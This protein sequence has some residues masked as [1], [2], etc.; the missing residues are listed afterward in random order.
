M[1]PNNAPFQVKDPSIQSHIHIN[2]YP[3]SPAL[4]EKPKQLTNARNLPE[5]H[6]HELTYHF[7]TLNRTSDQFIIYSGNEKEKDKLE[8]IAVTDFHFRNWSVY[9]PEKRINEPI[10]PLSFPIGPLIFYYGITLNNGILLHAAGLK[11][12]NRGYIFTGVSGIGKTTISN[13]WLQAGGKLINDDRLVLMKNSQGFSMYN[14]PMAYRQEA[15]E[16]NISSLFILRQS[17]ENKAQKLSRGAALARVMALCI[18][19]N[20]ERMLVDS[21]VNNV[22]QLVETIPVY[23]LGFKPDESVVKYIEDN[24][25]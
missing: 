10:N 16:C 2:I 19:H 23:E 11:Y 15:R 24:K 25:L 8:R 20:H 13:I 18:Q 17:R 4:K 9:I 14:S 5:F 21:L 12:K 3:G 7:Y 1:H 6:E 22:N